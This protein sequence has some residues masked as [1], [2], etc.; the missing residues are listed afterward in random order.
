MTVPYPI[1]SPLAMLSANGSIIFGASFGIFPNADGVQTSKGFAAALAFVAANGPRILQ[2]PAGQINIDVLPA[3][4][5]NPHEGTAI[6][7]TSAHSGITIQGAPNSTIIVPASNKIEIIAQ[8]G[9]TNV[10]IM[11]VVF[12][13]TVN[14]ILQNNDPPSPIVPNG[15]VAGLGNGAN[16]AIRQYTGAGLAL[17]GVTINGF[18]TAFEYYGYQPDN[19]VLSGI[20]Y[21][22]DYEANTCCYGLVHK[23][24]EFMA[25]DLR[26][27]GMTPNL[28]ANGFTDGP[29]LIYLT[30]R[31]GAAPYTVVIDNVTDKDSL[32]QTL[33]IRNG[34]YVAISNVA[35][36]N[37][38]GGV[39][40]DGLQNPVLSNVSVKMMYS[41]PVTVNY[42]SGAIVVLDC[43]NA[44]VSHCA[45]DIT[46]GVPTN[47]AAIFIQNSLATSDPSYQSWMNSNNALFDIK[48]ISDGNPVGTGVIRCDN[49]TFLNMYNVWGRNISSTTANNRAFIDVYG[50]VGVRILR[51]SY[52]ST[53]SDD[54]ALVRLSV[55][56]TGIDCNGIYLEYRRTMDLTTSS[57]APAM[58]NPDGTATNYFEYD[59][60]GALTPSAINMTGTNPLITALTSGASLHYE[61]DQ[62]H[63]FTIGASL[64]EW[65]RVTAGQVSIGGVPNA[66]ALRVINAASMVNRVE[67]RGATTGN[68][69]SLSGSGADTDVPFYLYTKG[70]GVV[71]LGITTNKIGFYG[72]S[73]SL[74][75]TGYGTPS[76]VSKTSALPG[77]GATLAQVGGTLAAL[78]VDLKSQGLIGA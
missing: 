45:I 44:N 31:S 39:L 28:H 47:T 27:S 40:I 49:Q 30:D 58:L 7:L 25:S 19:T 4:Q 63:I 14:G 69:A 48:I 52:L 3:N 26:G 1:P 76:N 13:N 8:M 24:T 75:P 64:T 68:A 23:P 35:C 53:Q 50:C 72:S 67:A 66:E 70:A 77:T 33:K 46:G 21:L 42:G 34:L 38:Y 55:G 15:G 20:L 62:T 11:D 32:A 29:H 18:N 5:I 12:D 6:I 43:Y 78:I 9:A 22:N 36:D 10:T 60:S 37:C 51:P 74:Q 54:H 71:R 65:M 56:T 59:L 73:G 16:C 61:A 2:L 57:T 17:R 41:L